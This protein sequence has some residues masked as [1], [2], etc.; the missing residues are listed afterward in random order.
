LDDVIRLR[1]RGSIRRRRA[2]L[3]GQPFH[4][5]GATREWEEGEKG[6]GGGRKGVRWLADV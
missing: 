6:K 4:D 1:M 2:R 3:H 5:G